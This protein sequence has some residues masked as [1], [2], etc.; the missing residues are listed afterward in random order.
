[1]K[2]RKEVIEKIQKL[3][4]LSKSDNEHE[5]FSALKMARKLMAKHNIEMS[6]DIEIGI[7][8]DD[9]IIDE[10]VFE[11]TKE[12]ISNIGHVIAENFKCKMYRE[13]CGR[14]LTIKFVGRPTDV[15]IAKETYTYAIITSKK[16]A[17]KMIKEMKDNGKSTSGAEREYLIGFA[18]GLKE[19]FEEQNRQEGESFE[20]S[21]LT[22]VCVNDYFNKLNLVKSKPKKVKY[23]DAY[24]NGY[25]DGK[26]FNKKKID[27]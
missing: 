16:L 22:P 13:K 24:V 12:G 18:I 25:N 19:A 21:M 7:E 8:E 20:L 4:A 10:A 14:S 9:T 5:A 15:N 11:T 3:L 17:K 23:S 26:A 6:E 1:M 27:G 2:T